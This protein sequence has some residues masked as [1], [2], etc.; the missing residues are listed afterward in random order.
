METPTDR[1]Q[2]PSECKHF[3]LWKCMAHGNAHPCVFASEL[4]NVLILHCPDFTP[5]IFENGE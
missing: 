5:K 3:N 4:A 2:R 1:P